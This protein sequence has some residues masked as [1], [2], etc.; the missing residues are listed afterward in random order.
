MYHVVAQGHEWIQTCLANIGRPPDVCLSIA[1]LPTIN[2]RLYIHL[3]QS[4]Q[5]PHGIYYANLHSAQFIISK[6]P[7]VGV[8]MRND[9]GSSP[10]CPL[11]RSLAISR[12]LLIND[13]R[14]VR[15]C[16]RHMLQE[17][18]DVGVLLG[19]YTRH[20]PACHP[21]LFD[22]CMWVWMNSCML[23]Q[24]SGSKFGYPDFTH[25]SKKKATYL[26][27][28]V[29]SV[30]VQRSMS[31]ACGI[32]HRSQLRLCESF[33]LEIGFPWSSTCTAFVGSEKI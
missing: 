6:C 16:M 33:M 10:A 23:I 24:A 2:H 19:S 7:T 32:F 21:C 5:A 22:S 14:V 18:N 20:S 9:G 30:Y 17:F 3:Y 13:K 27:Y 4:Y 31:G 12:R 8:D 28:I 26:A 15:S 25:I 11:W 1:H 29:F